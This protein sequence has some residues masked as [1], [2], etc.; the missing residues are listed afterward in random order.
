MLLL[1][2]LI[3][4]VAGP[5]VGKVEPPGWW[6]GHSISTVRLLVRGHDLAGA[7]VS[8]A[9]GVTTT[10][11]PRVSASGTS[12]FVDVAIDPAAAPGPRRL[13]LATASGATDLPF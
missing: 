12:L 4:L 11:E 8:A 6:P 13:R 10:G 1:A 3:A 9:P 5:V 2:A 7:R